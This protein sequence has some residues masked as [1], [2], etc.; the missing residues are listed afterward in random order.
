MAGHDTQEQL[1]AAGGRLL[2]GKV[3]YVVV[4]GLELG[5]ELVVGLQ[6]EG[7][8]VTLIGDL[9][10]EAFASR[11]AVEAA[12]AVAA[13]QVGAADLVVHAAASP[14]LRCGTPLAGMSEIEFDQSDV[15]LRATLYTFQAA[16]G[17]MASRGGAIVVVGPALAL[18]GARQLVPL[19][20]ASEGQRSLVKSAAR[21]WGHLGITVNWV[22][23]A[24]GQYAADLAGKGPEVPELGPPACALGRAPQLAADIAPVLAFIASRGGRCITGTTLNLDGGDWMTP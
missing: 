4:S 20:T 15:A 5:P 2:A 16:H 17:Q 3:A 18:V 23:A 6:A 11:R 7:A 1:G 10:A 13:E 22:G 12:F 24:D 8:R 14:A 21:Q 19:C 9:D